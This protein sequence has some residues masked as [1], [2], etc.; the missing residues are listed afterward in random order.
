MKEYLPDS[1]ICRR[2]AVVRY[3]SANKPHN[4]PVNDEVPVHGVIAQHFH[5]AL[6]IVNVLFARI[7]RFIFRDLYPRRQI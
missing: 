4:P 6:V 2:I 3:P 1:R 7:L 5:G